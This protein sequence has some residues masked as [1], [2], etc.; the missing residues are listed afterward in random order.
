MEIKLQSASQN[1]NYSSLQG[2]LLDNNLERT[3]SNQHIK[4]NKYSN[5]PHYLPLRFGNEI[6]S[7]WVIRGTGFL[8]LSS[9]YLNQ[10]VALVVGLIFIV[11]LGDVDSYLNDEF[12]K[13]NTQIEFTVLLFFEL[14]YIGI[15]LLKY[16][17][18]IVVG[19]KKA[20]PRRLLFIPK[21]V[22]YSLIV[23]LVESVFGIVDALL[24]KDVLLNTGANQTYLE[25][26]LLGTSSIVV[27]LSITITG[28]I[29]EE[30]IFRYGVISKLC[31][32]VNRI[33]AV[34]FSAIIF[35]FIHIGFMQMLDLS[36]FLSLMLT[37]LGSG[38]VLGA[39]YT[40][41]KNLL[42]PI[43]THIISNI[44]ATIIIMM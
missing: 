28:P 2:H 16:K 22:F 24:F 11:I 44:I 23:F 17:K 33:F 36:L 3:Q 43:I 35:A 18:R 21:V 10:V 12:L 41:E 20:V 26:A 25:S 1:N 37:Y 42:Y 31:F 19:L 40:Y 32:G 39:I 4:D 5:R 15:L 7:K 27:I 30:Y 13:I 14:L 29:I 6:A 8:I 9:F 34:F 38:L